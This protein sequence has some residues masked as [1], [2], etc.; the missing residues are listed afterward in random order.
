MQ[1]ATAMPLANSGSVG[2]EPTLGSMKPTAPAVKIAANVT[3]HSYAGTGRGFIAKAY[4][5]PLRLSSQIE[6][7]AADD[8][9]ECGQ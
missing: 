4:D 1:A 9:V 7:F 5:E 6:R 8:S 3:N 2:C